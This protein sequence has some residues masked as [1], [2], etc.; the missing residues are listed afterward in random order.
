MGFGPAQGGGGG[1]TFD[2][3]TLTEQILWG[4][5]L[6]AITH[7]L[8]PTDQPLLV[9]SA[10]GQNLNIQTAEGSS[11][12]LINI[13]AGTDTSG[14]GAGAGADFS[15]GNGAD[16]GELSLYGGDSDGGGTAGAR[17]DLSGGVDGGAIGSCE[18]TASGVIV[19]SVKIPE[20]DP[21][22]APATANAFDDE[23]DGSSLDGKWTT[24]SAATKTVGNGCLTLSP[25]DL[26][27]ANAINAVVAAPGSTFKITTK[28]SLLGASYADY[29]GAGLM[30]RDS[31]GGKNYQFMYIHNGG[32]KIQVNKFNTLNV[33]TGFAGTAAGLTLPSAIT[34]YLQVEQDSTTLYFRWS[35]DGQVFRQIFSEGK[36]AF[37]ASAADQVG[38]S[39]EAYLTSAEAHFDWIRKT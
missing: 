33:D 14:N 10:A 20:K 25:G 18:I 24:V 34:G 9:S 17:I 38:P 32:H 19:N 26:S 2:G 36:T 13:V 4:T 37:L 11:P 6:G 12:G 22:F 39:L 29:I 1:G 23:F 5:G 7:I 35:P 28:V 21:S 30:V 8:G 27:A 31:V 3:G 16:G 15:G